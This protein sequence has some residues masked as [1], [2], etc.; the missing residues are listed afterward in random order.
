MIALHPDDREEVIDNG[1]AI[2][3]A[4]DLSVSKIEA[5]Q[6]AAPGAAFGRYRTGACGA[7]EEEA[8]RAAAGVQVLDHSASQSARDWDR[9]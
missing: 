3:D 7:E 2:G 9:N 5:P 6:K 4:E 8:W 1:L